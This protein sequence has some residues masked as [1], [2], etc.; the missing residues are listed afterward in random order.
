MKRLI[1]LL[2]LVPVFHC[3]G[4]LSIVGSAAALSAG[5]PTIVMPTTQTNDIVLVF[6]QTSNETA[7]ITSPAG[8]AEIGTQAEMGTGTAATAGSVRLAVFWKRATGAESNVVVADSGNHTFARA[9]VIR[10]CAST[11]NPWDSM[12]WG[13][14]ATAAT[15]LSWQSAGFTYGSN[16]STLT[17]T[18][19]G[20]MILAV[21]T[22]GTNSASPQMSGETF[23]QLVSN[24]FE[25]NEQ[26]NGTIGLGGGFV[27]DMGIKAAAG[28]VVDS[29]TN[30]FSLTSATSTLYSMFII[31]MK[32]V[33]NQPVYIGH[34]IS[35]ATI[36]GTGSITP[37]L[38][39]AHIA[40]DILFLF[41]Q[42][43]NET[44][45][46]PAGYTEI[47]SQS[48]MATG[49]AATAGSLRIAVF[50]KR[51]GGSETNPT[52]TDTGD[53]T[54]AW[55][56]GWRD[57]PTTGNPWDVETVGLQATTA[58]AVDWQSAGIAYGSNGGTLTTAMSNT[59]V[60]FLVGHAVDVIAGTNE[61]TGST[62]AA[63]TSVAE[64]FKE[65]AFVD[66]TTNAGTGGGFALMTGEKIIAGNI[67][68]PSGN[69][70]SCTLATTSK[71]AIFA[72]ALKSTSSS[73]VNS[74]SGFF[75]LIYP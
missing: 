23:T 27:T 42:S 74:N 56:C 2:L 59:E 55:M 3:S 4:A 22:Q 69:D 45:T 58:T 1:P 32:P 41:V 5:A 33:P 26:D 15:A 65:G 36:A 51:D 29:S 43:S 60:I 48:S 72:L 62:A 66:L 39:Q 28:T 8:Y 13:V 6:V 9:V 67:I 16:G 40:N 53:H 17:T 70:F 35:S 19:K 49:T 25:E 14:Q 68:Q 31:A 10:G 37:P 73:G 30:N 20:C 21:T 50:W 54:M 75:N 7:S 11:G 52:V 57:C 24:L 44:I 34:T 46:A 12:V 18:A 71:H 63:L 61:V 38:P 47:D 64:P